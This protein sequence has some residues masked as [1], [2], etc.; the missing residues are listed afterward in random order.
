LQSHRHA[1][2]DG[3]LFIHSFAPADRFIVSGTRGQ[4]KPHSSS[5]SR[6]IDRLRHGDPKATEMEAD[7]LAIRGHRRQRQ[8]SACGR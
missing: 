3:G 4:Q 8:T 2:D 5:S 6:W 1:G 7:E